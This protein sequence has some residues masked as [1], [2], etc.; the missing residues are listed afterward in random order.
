MTDDE[1]LM[2]LKIARKL[3]TEGWAQCRVRKGKRTMTAATKLL[4]Q[5]AEV[6]DVKIEI[7]GSMSKGFARAERV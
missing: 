4:E 6:A 3:L 7:S 5:G 1:R 2:I